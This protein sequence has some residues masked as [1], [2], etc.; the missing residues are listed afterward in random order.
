[1]SILGAT[2][3]FLI[4]SAILLFGVSSLLA[5]DNTKHTP[6]RIRVWPFG[7]DQRPRGPKRTN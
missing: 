3:L 2:L 5:R 1:M 4:V 7:S 6:L